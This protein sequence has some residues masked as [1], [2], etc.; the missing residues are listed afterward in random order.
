MEAVSIP[1]QIENDEFWQH[2]DKLQKA[3][4][5]SRSAYCRRYGLNYYRFCYWA[6]KSNQ[7]CAV[8]KLVSVKLKPIT[9]QAAQNILCTLELNNGRCLKIHDT[10]ALSFILERIS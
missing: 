10:Q 8:N 9:N 3:S 2:H 1:D 5:L 4:D 6:K 7:V